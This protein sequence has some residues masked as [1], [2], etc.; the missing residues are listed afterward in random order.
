VI[1][2]PY[3]KCLQVSQKGDL[4][5]GTNNRKITI[6]GPQQQV[7]MAEYLVTQQLSRGGGGGGGGH[8][9]AAASASAATYQHPYPG[10]Y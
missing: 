8:H 9:Y 1:H 2:I 10:Q 7:D 3:D 6:T 4:I 5:P